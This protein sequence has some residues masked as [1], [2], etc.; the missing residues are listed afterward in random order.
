MLKLYA[1]T[2][3]YDRAI[4]GSSLDVIANG[5]NKRIFANA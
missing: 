2:K 1:E 5:G 3:A 4:T